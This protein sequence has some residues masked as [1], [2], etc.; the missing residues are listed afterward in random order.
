EVGHT[1][2]LRHNFQGSYDSLNYPDAYWR[3]REENL[4]EAQTLA[5]IYRLSNQTEAQIDGQMKQLQYSSIMDYGFGWANDLAGVGKYD[6]AA[7]VFGYTSDVYRAEGSRCARYDSQP[8]GAGCLAKLPGY[9]QVFKKRKGNLNAAGALMDRTE[10]GFTYDDPGLPSVTLLERFHYTTLAQAFPTLEDFAE[11]GREFMHYVDYLEAKGGEDRPIR[12]PFMFCSDEWEGGLISCHAWDQGADPFE[13]ARSKIEEYRATYPFVNFRRDRPWFDIWDPLFTYFFRTFLPLSDIFQSWYVAPYGDD[14]LFDRTYDLAINAGFSLL[15]EVLATPPYGQFCDTE[16]G[17]LIHISDEPVLQGDEYI[18]PDC[19]DG[20]RRVR[21]AP[22]EG[23]R[24]FSAYDPNAGYYFEYKPQEAGHYWATLAAV[25]ALVDPEAYVV[26]VEGDAGTYAISFYDWFDDELERLSNNVL[27]KNYAAFAPRGAP[28]QGEGGAWTTGLKHIPAAPL[29][30]S[31]AGGYFNAE[32]GEAVALD[33]SAGPPAGP[34]GLCNPCEAD[35]DC[36]GHTGFL[37][38]TYCQPLEDGSRVCLQDC[39]NSADLCP[40]GTECDPRGN[41]VPPAG[42][43]AACAALAGD[44]GPQNPLGDCAAGAT[45]VD[46]TCVEYPWEPVVESEPTFS[47]ATDILFY[48]FLFT[49]A[50]YSTRFNDQLN[51]FRPGSPNAVEADP[52]TSEIVQFTDPESGVTYAAVQ[53]RCDGGISG[54][55]TGLCGACDEDADCAGHTGFLGG[56]YCQPIG[57][58]EDD[59][60]CLQ[61]CTNDPTVCAAGDVCDGRGN[62]VP[63]LGICRDSGACSAE[64]PLGQCPAGQTCSGGACVTPFVPSEH[65]QFLRPD[66][67]GA[68]QLVRRGQALADAYNASLAAWYSYQGDDAAL[69][70]QLARRYFADRFRMRNH[71]DLLETVQATY[72]IFGRVY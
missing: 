23:R 25:W 52:N 37:D 28:V 18:D 57:D 21:I 65:C 5:D 56:T 40:A 8:D 11:R 48:G 69:D 22:G 24:R 54:G 46:G 61:D 68:V 16:D 36:A 38:G 42:T 67:T 62:C 51:V 45:C 35:N 26:G 30:D 14:P 9:I 70:N 31:Q 12:V 34:I 32:T 10:L 3:M 17:R 15:G 60:F 7:M 63:A 41:C 71:I 53:P 55:A 29:Y 20:S 6:H 49:T 33:P 1:L 66:D 64:N 43:L 27:S 39:T 50:S 2:G 59:F 58:N 72:A 4:T 44:C 47:L 13:L 19:P